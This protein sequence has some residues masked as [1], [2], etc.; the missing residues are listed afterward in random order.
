MK[1]L[2]MEFSPVSRFFLP[3]SSICP[4]HHHIYHVHFVEC[5]SAFSVYTVSLLKLA[6]SRKLVIVLHSIFVP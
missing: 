4:P 6:E 1:L 5:Q 3:L 2:I